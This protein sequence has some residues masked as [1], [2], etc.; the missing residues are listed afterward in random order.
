MGWTSIEYTVKSAKLRLM[1]RLKG[2]PKDSLISILLKERIRDSKKGPATEGERGLC[3]E[4]K[5]IWTEYGFKDQWEKTIPLRKMDLKRMLQKGEATADNQKWYNWR[6]SQRSD[7]RGNMARFM[8]KTRSQRPPRNERT[9]SKA[10]GLRTTMAAGATL[11]RGNKTGGQEDRDCTY[12]TKDKPETERHTCLECDNEVRAAQRA[13][14]RQTIKQN[15]SE[16]TTKWLY[17]TD[18]DMLAKLLGVISTG[19]RDEDEKIREATNQFMMEIA[20]HRKDQGE[21]NMT[22]RSRR[23]MK[24]RKE[25][26]REEPDR[27]ERQRW[28]DD[29]QSTSDE[30]TT[31]EDE[32]EGEETTG[33]E[34]E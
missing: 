27:R 1:E 25:R 13:K 21:P 8:K 7:D 6:N 12:C 2:K 14:W 26:E 22:N 5:E 20:E 17:S 28:L 16:K 30:D 3:D 18:R 34:R 24:G 19:N 29:G 33:E 11:I 31:E 32:S 23:S 4:T 9:T 15:C 10:D